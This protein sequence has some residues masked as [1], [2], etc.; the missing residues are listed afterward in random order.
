MLFGRDDVPHGGAWL[1]SVLSSLAHKRRPDQ[2]P[3]RELKR[4]PKHNLSALYASKYL[5]IPAQDVR[6]AGSLEQLPSSLIHQLDTELSKLKTGDELGLAGCGK[7]AFS[8]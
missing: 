5:T 3:A 1:F 2:E 7:N 4:E 8:E 6:T